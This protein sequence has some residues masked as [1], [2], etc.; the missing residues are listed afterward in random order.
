METIISTITSNKILMIIFILIAAL[1]I[2]S[3]LKRLI[4]IIVIIIIALVLYMSYMNYKGEKIDA[5]VQN[6]LNKGGVELKELQKK[7]DKMSDAID[8][9]NKVTK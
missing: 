6:Y 2:Y 5:M 7:K 3:V 4:K 9:A 1:I 8:A